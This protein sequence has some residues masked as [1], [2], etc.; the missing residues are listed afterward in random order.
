ME[1]PLGIVSS[2]APE[3]TNK[4]T[5][6]KTPYIQKVSAKRKKKTSLQDRSRTSSQIHYG[7][8]IKNK[9]V[10]GRLGGAAG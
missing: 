5:N 2:T 6:K 4:Q 3:K 1:S 10:L 7:L 9:N 8:S